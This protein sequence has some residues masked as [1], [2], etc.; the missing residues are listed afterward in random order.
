MVIKLYIDYFFILRNLVI[1][2]FIAVGLN[3]LFYLTGWTIPDFINI[4]DEVLN[5]SKHSRKIIFIGCLLLLVFGAINIVQ[6]VNNPC[7]VGWPIRAVSECIINQSYKNYDMPLNLV[8][9]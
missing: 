9:R 2:F 8:A 6:S 4:F 3:L 7:A 1:G 5:Q